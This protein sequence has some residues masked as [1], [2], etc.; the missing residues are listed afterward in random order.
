MTIFFNVR[1]IVGRHCLTLIL[2][3][4]AFAP[5]HVYAQDEVIYYHTDAVGSVRM[6]TDA[7]GAVVG[8]YDFLPFG[9]PWAA[10]P[11]PDVRQ[12]AGKER[13]AESG[14][15]YFGARYYRG[16]SGRFT[17]VDPVMN[18]E[19][20]LADPQRWNR[21]SYVFNR[22]LVMIDPDGREAGY[23]YLPNGQMVAPINGITPTMGK[24]L[25]GTLAAA[26]LVTAGPAAWRVAVGCFLAPSCQS[27]A[28]NLLE[29]AAGGAPSPLSSR[30]PL[31]SLTSTTREALL[32]AAVAE[33]RGGVSEAGRAL[34]SHAM[35]AGSWL[36]GLAQ[37]GSGA[38][39]TSA[40][41]QALSEILEGGNASFSTHKVWGDV[42]SVRLSDGRGAV[43]T[44]DGKFITFL[45]RYSKQ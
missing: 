45:E 13:D 32:E 5:A 8:R 42:M 30:P 19:A 9:E 21:Y 34:Q 43:W 20:A 39:N 44:V 25:A 15:D 10:P 7:N 23:I 40:A 16:V 38:A 11:T 37:G 4:I 36:K 2:S 24:V 17:T 12:F 29:E 22:P 27:G 26:A 6:I 18:V 31:P 35:R 1:T 14:L 3:A 28:M 33:G 41:R